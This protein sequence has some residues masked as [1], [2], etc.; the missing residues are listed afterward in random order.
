M[1]NPRNT[2]LIDVLEPNQIL[3]GQLSKTDNYSTIRVSIDTSV[4]GVL[5]IYHS[6]DS[7]TFHTFGDEFQ[8][9]GEKH[10]Q[11][12]VKGAFFYIEYENGN[13]QQ[14]N[15]KLYTS[16][17]FIINNEFDITLTPDDEITVSG[18]SFNGSN[19]LTYDENTNDK[20]DEIKTT[21]DNGI[22]TTI[23]NQITNYALETTQSSINS[24]IFKCNTDSVNV[25]NQIS[26]FST[27]STLSG[28]SNKVI[29]CDTSDIS[30]SV[31]VSNQI[32][33]F[34]T[35]ST[36]SD[37][38]DKVIKCD[39]DN[40][41][42]SNQISGYST[43]QNQVKQLSLLQQGDKYNFYGKNNEIILDTAEG[44]QVYA[45]SVPIPTVDSLKRE[46]WYYTNPVLGNKYNYYYFSNTGYLINAVDVIGQYC[47]FQNDAVSI[48]TDLV[49]ILAIYTAGTNQGWYNGR[50]TFSVSQAIQSGVK[51]LAYWGQN[52]SIYP[53][54]PRIQLSLSSTTGVWND[55]DKILTMS[56]GSN[57]GTPANNVKNLMTH[58]G[59]VSTGSI[60]TTTTFIGSSKNINTDVR[61]LDKLTNGISITNQISNYNL[62]STQ[63]EVK[64]QLE[65]SNSIL[66]DISNDIQSM[67]TNVA[68]DDT[69]NLV[70]DELI[71][72]NSKNLA[73][74]DGLEN[75]DANQL[76]TND[77]LDTLITNSDKFN[78][79]T[80]GNLLVASS[81]GGGG[82]ASD[83]NV[84]N[85]PSTQNVSLVSGNDE[86]TVTNVGTTFC[87]DTYVRN[88]D[89]AITNADLTSTANNTS[90]TANNTITMITQLNTLGTINSSIGTT[91][92]KLDTIS[93]K[94]DGNINTNIYDGNGNAIEST[95]YNT[96]LRA[97]CVSI[98]NNAVETSVN[99]FPSFYQVENKPSTKLDTNLY[100][101]GNQI[102][103]TDVGAQSCVDVYVQNNSINT[104]ITN[105]ELTDISLD[106]N[107]IKNK[108]NDSVDTHLYGFH[109]S[110]YIPIEVSSS[111]HLL[112]N[113]STQDG[114]GDDITS[115]LISTQRGLD[116]NVINNT[117]PATETTLS[118]IK[119]KLDD[120]INLGGT[121]YVRTS[122]VGTSGQ[123]ITVATSGFRNSVAVSLSDDFGNGITSTANALNVYNSDL[124]NI[125]S[126]IVYCDT[127]SLATN[128]KLTDCETLLNDIK[129]NTNSINNKI[130]NSNNT[131]KTSLYDS[132]GTN[133]TSVN[134]GLKTCLD[135]A[136]R[137][138]NGSSITSTANSLNVYQSNVPSVYKTILPTSTIGSQ[139]NLLNGALSS[140]SSSTALNCTTFT[141]CILSYKDTLVSSTGTIIIEASIDGVNYNY[142]GRIIPIKYSG[143]VFSNRF[144]TSIVDLSPFTSVRLTNDG[145]DSIPSGLCSLFSYGQS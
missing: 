115:T 39:T 56:V 84:L 57:S 128:S 46:G 85:F 144:A 49:P 105:Q 114:N 131:I 32:S 113:C 14:L 104:F 12:S 11:V 103:S 138:S 87:L 61:I 1:S 31:N 106:T 145:S 29:T 99:N 86:L 71:T 25:S 54:L 67:N 3:R 27:E 40:V 18:L 50:K 69:L 36:L 80:S 83:V 130:I 98:E 70:K 88:N 44:I 43:S 119:T 42:I 17:S 28:L 64:T 23:S 59:Y 81:G 129:T 15:F 60:E 118:S 10:K 79:D 112:A 95:A 133:F 123:G 94:L 26:G 117:D 53:E 21:L 20:L 102:T 22:S 116:V 139:G 13:Q 72:L 75:I 2:F 90:T 7:K 121:D 4:S 100:C 16:L 127:T 122:L 110:S 6:L 93:T 136:V 33:G 34:A 5:K 137:D 78:F 63:F 77:K 125:N 73:L 141:K 108:L 76:L 126:N 68:K 62:E 120:V 111:G 58:C 124:A 47:I 51:Y 101:S 9:T 19:L 89:I 82:V 8:I 96:N 91:N 92:T 66:I 30:G 132:T 134:N 135:V 52:P 140:S 45:D 143:G 38:S 65:S 24:K 142:I 109:N 74:N 41:N 55:T 48:R 97:L 35:E 107:A 37:L